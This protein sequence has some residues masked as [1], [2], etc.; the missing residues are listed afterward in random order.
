MIALP[1]TTRT[2]AAT[3]RGP[4]RS[5]CLPISRAAKKTAHSYCVAFTGATIDTRPRSNAS[6]RLE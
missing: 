4:M 6:S 1:A 3:R 5:L 2:P